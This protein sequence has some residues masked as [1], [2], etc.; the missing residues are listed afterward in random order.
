MAE[1][2]L[3]GHKPVPLPLYPEISESLAQDPTCVPMTEAGNLST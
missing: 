1:T 2:D 3:L